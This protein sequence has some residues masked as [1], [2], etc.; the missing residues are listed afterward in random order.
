MNR[1][2][3]TERPV[4]RRNIRISGRQ[5]HQ[6]CRKWYAAV[7]FTLLFT[8]V[9]A[10]PPS[11]SETD[12]TGFGAVRIENEIK[13]RVP[14]EKTE[15]V[16]KW[17]QE[18]FAGDQWL[19]PDK[20]MFNATFGDEDFEDVYYDTPDLRMLAEESGIRHRTRYVHS[21][22]AADKD[23]R[24]L[25]QAKL[26]RGDTTGLAR[27]EIKFK[28][29]GGAAGS[30]LPLAGMIEESQRGEFEELLGSLGIDP[31][32]IRPVLTLNQNRRRVYVN[33]RRGAFATLTLDKCST[34][35]WGT[36]LGWTDMELELNEI[37]YT[38]ADPIE[39]QYMEE[40]NMAM[41]DAILSEFPYIVQDQTPKYNITF[42]AIEEA[43]WM[44]VRRMIRWGL[45]P[46]D[47][48]GIV[49]LFLLGIA[50]VILYLVLRWRKRKN[51]PAYGD[52]G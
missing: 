4:V 14:R 39:R 44:P 29:S 48:I 20:N 2:I 49:S 24:R 16:W 32:N 12:Q 28:V 35:S 6:G 8:A 19:D 23:G 1:S 45:A 27:S 43:A 18:L 15:T 9:F 13:L 31:R 3:N 41:L 22:S 47:F 17:M 10:A 34:T 33:D 38:E 51:A 42:A 46:S 36:N 40:I 7:F 11:I 5:G 37:R 26:N 21:G 25:V 30:D 50:A 52:A